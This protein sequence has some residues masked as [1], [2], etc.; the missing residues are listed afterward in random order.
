MER[1]EH[2]FYNKTARLSKEQL[3]LGDFSLPKNLNN[4]E[5]AKLAHE[6]LISFFKENDIE[7]FN[8]RKNEKLFS[9]EYKYARDHD[10]FD[11]ALFFI[12]HDDRLNKWLSHDRKEEKFKK[13]YVY[14]KDKGFYLDKFENDVSCIFISF[15]FK[16]ELKLKY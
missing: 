4:F 6:S 1:K 5:Y 3:D 9:K 15:G 13:I 14:L 10:Y 16:H 2:K 11:G 8:L 7:S 12:H